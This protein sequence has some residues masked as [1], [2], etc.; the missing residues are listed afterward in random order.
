MGL[1]DIYMYNGMTELILRR[2]SQM[3]EVNMKNILQV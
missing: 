1:I 3:M 2:L